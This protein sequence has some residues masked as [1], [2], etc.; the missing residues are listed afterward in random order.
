MVKESTYT[1]EVGAKGQ[2]RLIILNH[3]CNPSTI[4]FL[5]SIGLTKGSSV[6]DVGCG[7]GILSSEI[8]RLVGPKGRVVGVDISLEQLE[9]ARSLLANQKAQVDFIEKSVSEIDTLGEQF[10]IVYS[11]FMLCH[12]KEPEVAISKMLKLLKPGG[13]FACEDSAFFE[14]SSCLPD[15]TAYNQWKDFLRKQAQVH[16]TDFTIGQRLPQILKNMGFQVS[17]VQVCEPVLRTPYEKKSLRLGVAE[18]TPDLVKAGLIRVE[19]SEETQR[20]LEVFERE[21]H[22]FVPFLR[23]IQVAAQ[24]TTAPS[25]IRI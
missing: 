7:I 8:A 4:N 20:A 9:V 10:D 5:R 14:H 24:N 17:C 21:D 22:F 12:L 25:K 18:I 2:E 23:Y 15:S 13:M 19:D 1:L 6:L 11:R 3:I 16:K